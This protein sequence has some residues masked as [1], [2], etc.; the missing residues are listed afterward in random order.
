MVDISR[1]EI[2]R[3]MIED[4]V[5]H[6]IL[7]S[8]DKNFLI[9]KVEFRGG[10]FTLERSFPNTNIGKLDMKE[11]SKKFNNEEKIRAYFGI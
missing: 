8:V 10:K 1:V 5:E 11:E 7:E 6:V 9:L 2:G 3:K 4:G